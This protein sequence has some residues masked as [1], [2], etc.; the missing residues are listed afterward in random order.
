MKLKIELKPRTYFKTAVWAGSMYDPVSSTAKEVVGGIDYNHCRSFSKH[1][2]NALVP[3]KRYDDSET[4]RVY[5]LE[6]RR[7][8]V[9]LVTDPKLLK[10]GIKRKVVSPSY[11]IV[12]Y[13]DIPTKLLELAKLRVVQGQRTWKF[14]ALK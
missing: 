12:T 11:W 2:S 4:V 3:I 7:K 13:Y 1:W 6:K 5:S 10:R 8:K 14:E 9:Q